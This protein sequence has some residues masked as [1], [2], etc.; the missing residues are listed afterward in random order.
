MLLGCR[1]VCGGWSS[2]EHMEFELVR[3]QYQ[4]HDLQ[5]AHSLL[6]DRLTRHFP[7]LST[8][9][10][11]GEQQPQPLSA[12]FPFI[13]SITK[14]IQATNQ[15]CLLLFTPTFSTKHT[16]NHGAF[17]EITRKN[18]Q[19]IFQQLGSNQVNK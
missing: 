13:H 11:V 7:H 1:D 14:P 3:E 4:L 19:F 8:H 16:G 12:Q 2:E 5:N 6:L 10:L 15:A 9:S 18:R 17:L